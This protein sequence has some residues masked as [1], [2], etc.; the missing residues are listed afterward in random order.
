MRTSSILAAKTGQHAVKSS[1]S[2]GPSDLKDL[3]CPTTP[4]TP[5]ARGTAAST[6]ASSNDATAVGTIDTAQRRTIILAKLYKLTDL[7]GQIA[8]PPGI[9]KMT[10]GQLLKLAEDVS[11]IKRMA[12]SKASMGTL[13]RIGARVATAY[14]VD[15]ASIDPCHGSEAWK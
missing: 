3:L 15:M 4:L 11:N 6:L 10:Y 7:D 2:A 5:P 9:E 13:L 1:T 12:R 14:G 8:V